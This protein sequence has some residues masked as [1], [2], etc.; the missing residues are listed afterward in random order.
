MIQAQP[1]EPEP[2]AGIEGDGKLLIGDEWLDAASGERFPVHNPADE[3][4]IGTAAAG[5][6]EDVDRAVRAARAAFDSGAW[7]ALLPAQR[8]RIL[9]RVADLIEADEDAFVRTE[10]RENGMPVPLAKWVV[11]N[12]AELFRYF[13]GWVTKI[14]GAT[15][16]ISAGGDYHCYTRRE[17]I[18]VAALIVPWNGPLLMACQK[19]APALAAGCACILKPAEDTPLNAL[20][21][22]RLLLEAGVPPGMVNIVTGFGATAGGALVDHPDVDKVSFTGSIAV[23]KEIVRRAAGNLKRVTLELGGKS[24]VIVLDD[25]DFAIAVAGVLGGIMTNSGQQCI[26]GSRLYVQRAIYDRFLTALADAAEQLKLGDGFDAAT[27]L[28]PVISD[29]QMRRILGYVEGGLADGARLV[30]GGARHGAT[31]YFVQPTILAEPAANARVLHEEIFGPVLAAVPFDDVEEAVG[32]ANASD[33]GL[34]GAVYTRDVGSAH[35]L[36]RR[37]RGGNLFVNCHGTYDPSMPFGGFR[38]SGWGRE[39]GREGLDS[40]LETKSV[41][42]AL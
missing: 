38:Q 40:Y 1:G 23:G 15:A 39:L 29:K 35:R 8:A 10:V 31:G 7:T 9:F 36:A 11:A 16:D 20:R 26:A 6:R 5:D 25:A 4:Q 22:G 37:I 34:A 32:L 33:Y 12:C 24:P 14:G 19:L 3:Q 13:A 30:T 21:L 28:G 2:S 17:P 18:G 42:I 41:F 27:H